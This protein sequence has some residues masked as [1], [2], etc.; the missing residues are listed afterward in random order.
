MHFDLVIKNGTIIS[1]EESFS[2]D[3]GVVDGR[4]AFVGKLDDSCAADEIYDAKGLHVLPG[5]IDAH[6]HFRDPG[7]TEKEDFETGSIAAAFG[8]VTC[9]ADMPNVIPVTSTAERFNEKVKIAKDKSYIDF[10]LF[11]LLANDNINEMEELK[12]SGALGFKVFLGTSTGDV[13]CPSP[14]VLFE[15]MQLCA[16]LGLRAGFHCENSEL[17]SYF[18]SLCKNISGSHRAEKNDG[19][20]LADAR[21]VISEA[22][23][24]QTAV[25]Y[26]KYTNAKIHIHH[27]TSID[28]VQII[29]E[30]KKN[31]LNITSETCPHYL[32][33]DAASSTH[34]VYPPI[35]EQIHRQGL[36]KALTGNPERTIDMIA[37]DHAPHSASD[38]ALPLWDAPAGLAGVE[39]FVPLMLNEVNKG[40]FSLNDFARLASVVP[41]KIWGIYPQKGSLQTGTDADFTIVDMN[42]KTKI[43][44]EALHSKSKTSPYDGMEVQGIPVATIVRGKFV[45][46][47]GELTGVKGYGE[48]VTPY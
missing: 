37:T 20:L 19:L 18:T 22:L 14:G 23:A 32:L 8:G 28:G 7:L 33:L 9:A 31:G 36:M 25:T 35:R 44:A 4:I 26:A 27:I 39:T 3:I 17:N 13:A 34:R 42:K 2:G 1:P 46:K 40:S 43:L 30:A 10:G 41:A 48:L 16:K 12:N 21:P 45:M 15:Q 24:I 47:D 38:K 29:A 11:A 5:I 6:V